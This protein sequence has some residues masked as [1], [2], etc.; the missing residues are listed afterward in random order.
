M[1]RPCVAD[2]P[3][4]T[5]ALLAQELRAIA[6]SGLAYAQNPYDVDRFRRVLALSSELAGVGLPVTGPE[7]RRAYLEHLAHVTPL[8]A[9][10]AVVLRGGQ[11]LLM[12]RGDTGLWGLPGGLA[13]VGETPAGTAERELFEETG[14]RGRA[15]R[16]LG[17]L[18]SR[19]APNLHGLHLVAPVFLVGAEGEPHPTPE[20]SEVGFFDWDALP[21]LHPGHE[22]SLA[23]VRE[24]LKTGQPFF[25]PE[26]ERVLHAQ[27]EVKQ[28]APSRHWKV[29]L[30]RTVARLGGL[31]LLRVAPQS[32]NRPG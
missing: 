32:S 21:P 12:R 4:P 15:A 30:A 3:Q 26:P 10:E 8:L 29:M 22:R 18:D 14:L 20:A 7:V 28:V 13:E 9:A 31:F 6:L 5:P 1:T 23:W 19:F 11:V 27:A 25:E 16:L 2:S 24:A 17:L